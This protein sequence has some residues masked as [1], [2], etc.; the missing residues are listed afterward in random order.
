[1]NSVA[2]VFES[3]AP[4]FAS[5]RT[6]KRVLRLYIANKCLE[7]LSVN[8]PDPG[9]ALIAE[10]FSEDIIE[11]R[12]D[13]KP[14]D[15]ELFFKTVRQR[16]DV[17]DFNVFGNKVTALKLNSMVICYEELRIK[18]REAWLEKK[19]KNPERM[20]KP[21]VD[22]KKY[23]TA[24]LDRLSANKEPVKPSIAP[25]SKNDE[26]QSYMKDFD[27]LHYEQCKTSAEQEKASIKY[28]VYDNEKLDMTEYLERR[29]ENKTL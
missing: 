3:Q 21:P 12:Y 5:S 16:Q 7:F 25:E 24:I 13:W 27:R 19:Y 26:I 28:V 2:E 8:S 14:Q 18:E 4:T 29:I 17:P 20:E 10:Q 15:I 23:T 9:N 11:T 22:V 6:D 1:M